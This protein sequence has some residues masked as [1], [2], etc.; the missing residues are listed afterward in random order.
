M[1]PQTWE[2]PEHANPE[3]GGVK[4]GSGWVVRLALGRLGLFPAEA[5]WQSI[6]RR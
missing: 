2:D 5:A 6:P 1:L 4:V 3:L